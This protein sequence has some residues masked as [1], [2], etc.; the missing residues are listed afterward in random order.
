MAVEISGQRPVSG[1]IN[2][3]E[4]AHSAFH[5]RLDQIY[6]DN[7]DLK[8]EAARMCL[9]SL[10]E[11]ADRYGMN[12]NVI[13]VRSVGR[14]N[15][16][17][18]HIDHR[19]GSVNPICI[20]QMWLVAEPRD[21]DLV[22]AKNVESSQFPDE[23]FR[24]SGCLPAGEK[25]QDWDAWCHDEFKRRKYDASITWSNYIRAAVLYFQHLHTTDEGGL[26]P[27]IRGMNMMVY[28][29]IPI[30]AGLSSSSALVMVAAEATIRIN[31]LPIH[32]ADLVEHW[33]FAEWYVG[34]RGG[35]SDHAAIIYGRP[36][37]ILHIRAFPL[38]VEHA[39]LPAGHSLVLA[40]CGI[41]AKKQ[42]GAR[43]IF[44]SRVAAYIFGLMMIRENFPEYADKLERLRDVNPERLGV[45]EVQIYRM[46]KSLPTSV[47]R[48]DILE[49]LPERERKIRRV[50][51]SH[52]EP[53][54][55]YH[56][57]QICLYG[58]TECIRAGMVPQCLRTGDMKT[59]GELVNISHD[60]D[61][62]TKLVGTKRVPTDNSYPDER[63]D[64]LI[65]DLES[66]DPR[67]I[68]RASLWRQSGGYN[69]SLPE[70]D[71]LVDIARA[72][73]GVVGA[74]LVGAGMGGCIVVVIEDKYAPKVIENMAEQ[75]YRPRNQPVEAEIVT[76]VG[77]LCT[78]AEAET[79]P[80]HP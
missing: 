77:G 35:C 78:M 42:A 15:L 54:Q 26:A 21:D 55:G 22:L 1:W 68:G 57:R 71:M 79:P 12:R 74:G 40:N 80:R 66:G 46:V 39:A 8:A 13:I 32:P 59:F 52:D 36:H 14:V 23:Q 29:N 5:S 75:Y 18:T 4:D 43:N 9:R 50:F 20:K 33:G 30:A 10:E 64:A 70:I 67:R 49:L 25:I 65:S 7:E 45:D 62:V 69:V 16:L 53:D 63:I 60:G 48:A 3:I 17:G 73:E 31:S 27:A 56:V 37:T 24:I 61:R 76:P 44:N 41:E 2:L 19:G 58:I 34:T 11:F 72:T 6:G 38:T 51:R 28:G 47:S